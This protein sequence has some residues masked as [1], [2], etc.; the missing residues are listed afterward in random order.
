MRRR[1][2]KV[3]RQPEQRESRVTMLTREKGERKKER[4]RKREV[5]C[6]VI[7]ERVHERGRPRKR[8]FH[9]DIFCFQL[10][11]NTKKP[12]DTQRKG[13]LL[14]LLYSRLCRNTTTPRTSLCH[15]TQKKNNDFCANNLFTE[16]PLERQPSGS[17]HRPLTHHARASRIGTVL[18]TR[19]E[20][21]SKFLRVEQERIL[22]R[23]DVPPSD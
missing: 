22:R 13:L 8:R 23:F 20:N 1:L 5:A 18:F 11:L 2:E 7:I 9:K 14:L 16:T 21:V 6:N 10:I 4:K 3:L 17:A 19:T 15:A 12:H